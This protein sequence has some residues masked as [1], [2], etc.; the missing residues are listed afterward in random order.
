M[1]NTHKLLYILP[2]LAYLSELLPGKKE[3]SFEVQSFKQY[4]GKLIE[5]G[6]FI[7][8]NL[9][10]LIRKLDEDEYEFILPD[11]LFTNTIIN[12]ERQTEKEVKEYL[13]EEVIPSL[14]ISNESHQI[15]TFILSEYKGTYKVQ[16]STIQKSLLSPLKTIAN[17]EKVKVNNIFPLSW[18]IKSLISLEP[19]LSILQ[20]GENLFMAKHYIGV[21]EPLVDSVENLDRFVEAIKTLKGTEPSLQTVY[22]LTDEVVEGKLKE[23]LDG[24]LPIQQLAAASDDNAKVPGFI[25]KIITAS[26]RT[27][28][29]PDFEVPQFGIKDVESSTVEL[30]EES[31]IDD[32]AY[33]ESAIFEEEDLSDVE[34]ELPKPGTI[35]EALADNDQELENEE[36]LDKNDEIQ[37]DT[38]DLESEDIEEIEISETSEKQTG[39]VESSLSSELEEENNSKLAII[40][41]DDEED[42]IDLSMFTSTPPTTFEKKEE[43]VAKT[44]KASISKKE[45]LKNNDGTSSF[46]K[47][48]L[49]GLGSFLLTVA[50]GVGIGAGLLKLS[51][52]SQQT[53]E[54]QVEWTEPE[55]VEEPEPTPKIE[56]DRSEYT[57]RVVN[58]TPKAGYAGQIASVLKEK[59][60][61]KVDAKN[62]VEDYEPGIYLLMNEE[63]VGLLEVISEDLELEISFVEGAEA[64]DPS[65]EYDAVV[66]LAE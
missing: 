46:I 6:K 34:A 9:H 12:V 3:H 17:S 18:V 49:I 54:P 59:E 58:A 26:M 52:P 23:L 35:N 15:Q 56:V 38:T 40:E 37:S 25:E 14:H 36:L 27:I 45:V 66:V 48:F 51:Q 41:K 5:N 47:V 44:E 10:S 53:E 19:S 24:V 61:A 33:P 55:Q 43:P 30:V 28:S 31:S 20:M 62:A 42:D 32:T 13:K 64:E 21:D 2:D 50:I 11:D 60:Y 57:I 22:L 8:Q 63:V 4:N 39:K 29:I 7:T 1:L 16:L 65:D